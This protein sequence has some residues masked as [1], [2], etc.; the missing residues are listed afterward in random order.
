MKHLKADPKR[1]QYMG[2]V[3]ESTF[4]TVLCPVCPLRDWLSK[5]D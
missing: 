2:L 5:S 4:L 3:S 1:F